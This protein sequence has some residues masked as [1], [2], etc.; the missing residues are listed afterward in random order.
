MDTLA[1][2]LRGGSSGNPAIIKGNAE[3]S[4]L[5]ILISLHADDD[6][7]MPSDG[8]PLSKSQ[9]TIVKNWINA[10]A[11]WKGTL[12]PKEKPGKVI[13]KLTDSPFSNITSVGFI[14]S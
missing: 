3:K 10:G 11:P 9:Q 7:I 5:Y 2:A 14:K 12:A 8:D 6:D 13:V 4:P 1:G